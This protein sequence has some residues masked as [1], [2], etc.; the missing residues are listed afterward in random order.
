MKSNK[1]N[2]IFMMLSRLHEIQ[3]WVKLLATLAEACGF[4]QSL[5]LTW[6]RLLPSVQFYHGFQICISV[7]RT[8]C[9][10][11]KRW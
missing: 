11:M 3:L 5:L 4:A 1:Q 10:C 9:D 6:Q 8:I 2:V 7:L